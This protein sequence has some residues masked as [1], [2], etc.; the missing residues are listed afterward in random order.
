MDRLDK[1]IVYL[2]RAAFINGLLTILAAMVSEFL[3]S[4]V[5]QPYILEM[6]QCPIWYES[7]AGTAL[8]LLYFLPDSSVRKNRAIGLIY[9]LTSVLAAIFSV[10]LYFCMM[11]PSPDH[12]MLWVVYFI[13]YIVPLAVISCLAMAVMVDKAEVLPEDEYK[14]KGKIPSKVIA[15]LIAISGLVVTSHA[16]MRYE[17]PEDLTAWQRR[18]LANSGV[19]MLMPGNSEEGDKFYDTTGVM[20]VITGT[21]RRMIVVMFEGEP[22]GYPETDDYVNEIISEETYTIDGIEYTRSVEKNINKDYKMIAYMNGISFEYNNKVY[23]AMVITGRT[24]AALKRDIDKI[25][26]TF[27]IQR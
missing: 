6:G 16:F 9:A 27:E 2:K 3:S 7:L 19:S 15:G 25:L 22:G 23:M 1:K 8:M 18:E 26:G 5:G 14:G 12:V 20:H 17:Q 13:L 24:N 21:G 10:L 4:M 11:L